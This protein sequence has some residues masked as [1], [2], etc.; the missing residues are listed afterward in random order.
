[1]GLSWKKGS[2]L[3]KWVTLRK[4]GDTWKSGSHSRKEK[5]VKIGRICHTLKKRSH[6][7]LR[8]VCYPWR[9]MSHLEKWVTFGKINHTYKNAP[10]LEKLFTLGKWVTLVKIGHTWKNGLHVQ[11]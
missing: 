4:I 5:C 11:K 9:N 6:Y 3:E 10:N 8:K 7:E 1:M 2:D